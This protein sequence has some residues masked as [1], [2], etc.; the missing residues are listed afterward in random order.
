M[1]FVVIFVSSK[2]KMHTENLHS[3]Y[4]TE[5]VRSNVFLTV[6]TKNL[7]Y[8]MI[9][10]YLKYVQQL[11]YLCYCYIFDSLTLLLITNLTEV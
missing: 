1:M 4:K 8:R 6:A 5:I 10:H 3:I 11:F 7:S 9:I 2:R